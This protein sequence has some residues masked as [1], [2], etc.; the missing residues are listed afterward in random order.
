MRGRGIRVPAWISLAGKLI[1]AAVRHP[2]TRQIVVVGQP[3]FG[4]LGEAR[5]WASDLLSDGAS[6]PTEEPEGDA[7]PGEPSGLREEPEEAE[8]HDAEERPARAGE[9]LPWGYK[10]ARRPDRRWAL[11][12]THYRNAKQVL[13]LEA[14]QERSSGKAAESTPL[15]AWIVIALIIV[16][17]LTLAT[18]VIAG[19]AMSDPT[20]SQSSAL[21]NV[22][23]AFF[24]ILGA[25]VG[26]IVGKLT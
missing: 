13:L 20:P 25:L 17:F 26:V 6:R 24:S 11:E 7:G 22:W 15:F 4:W 19:L 23:S 14:S 2:N 18:G 8:H 21:Q 16:M 10:R 3:S 5:V 1:A 9:V 12:E